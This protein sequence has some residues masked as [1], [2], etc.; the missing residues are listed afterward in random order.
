MGATDTDTRQPAPDREP[1][2]GDHATDTR[3]GRRIY[4]VGE[5][6]HTA[7][8]IYSRGVNLAEHLD[9]D[10]QRRVVWGVFHED[11][12]RSDRELDTHRD[13]LDAIG[14]GVLLP[15]PYPVSLVAPLVERDGEVRE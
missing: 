10:P 8:K 9:V 11:L 13:V 2:A 5:H 4:V 15:T 3:N 1:E 12:L 14:E 7:G 6:D